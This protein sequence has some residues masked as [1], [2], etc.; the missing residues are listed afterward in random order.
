MLYCVDLMN[1]CMVLT[2]LKICYINTEVPVQ[3]LRM[4]LLVSE[5]CG[6]MLAFTKQT[7]RLP[8]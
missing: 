6:I 5:C 2:D 3:S 4:N 1:A 7:T 8:L